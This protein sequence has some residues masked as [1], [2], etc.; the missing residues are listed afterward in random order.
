MT[1][2]EFFDKTASENIAACLTHAPERVIFI[3]DSTKSMKRHMENYARV[4]KGRGL[5]VEILYRSVSKSNLENAVKLLQQIV[6]TYEDCVFDI[7]GGE[8]IL[9]V[10]LGMVF[11][12]N[13]NKNIRI[14]RYNLHNNTAYDCDSNG[15]T[16]YK[17]QPRLSVDEDV[18]IYGGEVAYG[19]VSEEKTYKWQITPELEADIARMWEICKHGTKAWNNQLTVFAAAEEVGKIS[20]DGLVTV[21]SIDDINRRLGESGRG[22]MCDDYVV[23]KLRRYGLLMGFDDDDGVLS[24]AYKD[25]RVKRCLVKAG[26]VLEMR[27]YLAAMKLRDE[28]GAPVYHD[29]VNGVFIDWDGKLLGEEGRIGVCDTE[30]EVDVMMMHG[31]VPVF[32]SCK[33]GFVESDELYKLNIVA[34]RFGGKYARKVLVASAISVENDHRESL[35]QR[36]ADMNIRLIGKEDIMNDERL[37]NK[38]KNLWK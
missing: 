15:K 9:N 19:D 18:L 2:I 10:A 31:M 13:P 6:D 8:E 23:G 28:D 37:K 38:L 36:M 3:G 21:A 27:V 20:E 1:Y 35:K 22:Y 4:F 30:N 17:D 5:D 7:T 26:Q 32:V 34:E 11:A 12:E 14:T 29:V 24:V 16:E 33:N 25:P